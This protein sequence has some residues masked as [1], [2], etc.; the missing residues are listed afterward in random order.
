MRRGGRVAL[1]VLALALPGCRPPPG[2]LSG[3]LGALAAVV[4]GASATRLGPGTGPGT[5]GGFPGGAFPGTQV[6]PAAGLPPPPG[7]SPGLGPLPAPLPGQGLGPADS[8]NPASGGRDW[9]RVRTWAYQLQGA[10]PGVLAAFPADLVVID[11]AGRGG[12]RA[13][14]TRAEIQAVR[15]SG[16]RVVAYLSIG[17]AEDYRSYW[18]PGWRPGSP[19]WLGSENPRWKGNYTVEYWNPEW[20]T[21]VRTALDALIDLGFD[22]VYLDIVD[23]Y[24]RFGSRPS[25]RTEMIDLVRA[26]AVHARGRAGNDF[27]VFPQNAVELAADSGYLSVLTGVGKEETWFRATDDPTPDG[28]RRTE[29]AQLSRVRAAGRLVLT[30]DYAGSG[31]NRQLAVSRARALGFVP[32]VTGV[33]LDR[34][35]P[36]G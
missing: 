29:E 14:M 12:G 36:Q 23:G 11:P 15:A 1:L 35:T 5:G 33:E 28:E 2:V 17:E 24:R 20:R 22:G 27:G 31:A 8:G 10:D 16:K 25:A 19:A 30:V 21:I 4:S 6:G 3:L 26:I 18:R 13:S 32:Y 7:T 9:G 34:L